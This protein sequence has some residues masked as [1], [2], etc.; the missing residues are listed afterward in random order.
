MVDVMDVHTV[1][2]MVEMMDRKAY[3]LA[4]LMDADRVDQMAES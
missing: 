1:D 3:C 4:E 2:V